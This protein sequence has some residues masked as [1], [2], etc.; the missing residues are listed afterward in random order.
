MLMTS[1]RTPCVRGA[2]V[3]VDSASRGEDTEMQ[4]W[5]DDVRAGDYSRMTY[6][7]GD[8]VITVDPPPPSR[9]LVHP[10]HQALRG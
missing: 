7:A 9:S 10:P 4:G 3:G 8:G 2:L 6:A 5:K 1:G